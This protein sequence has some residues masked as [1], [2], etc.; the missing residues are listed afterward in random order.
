MKCLKL[1]HRVGYALMETVPLHAWFALIETVPRQCTR[2][3][4]PSLG[5]ARPLGTHSQRRCPGYHGSHSQRR[6]HGTARLDTPFRGHDNLQGT[7]SQRRYLVRTPRDGTTALMVRTHR[8]GSMALLSGS[9]PKGALSHARY[10]LMEKVS[11]VNGSHS[12]RQFRWHC[13]LCL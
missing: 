5:H 4:T 12:Q 10:A 6:S 2:R 3:D 1:K 9:L 13:T 8:D 11:R 7:H